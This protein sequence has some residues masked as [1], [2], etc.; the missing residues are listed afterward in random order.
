MATFTQPNTMLL[1]GGHFERTDPTLYGRGTGG[2]GVGGW[3]EMV[4]WSKKAKCTMTF[5]QDCRKGTP[6]NAYLGNTHLLFPPV[7]Q[8]APIRRKRD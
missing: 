7:N 2:E 5:D 4:G 8:Q 1:Q 6:L 3:G